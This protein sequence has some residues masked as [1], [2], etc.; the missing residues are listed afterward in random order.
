MHDALKHYAR[1][2]VT[3]ED[4]R[5]RPVRDLV[6][7]IPNVEVYTAIDLGCG[8]ANSTEVLVQRYPAAQVGGIDNSPDMIDAARRRLP[9]L[10]FEVASV[11]TWESPKPLDVILANA[12]LQWV[13]DHA[14]LYPRLIQQLTPGGTLAVQTPDNF[15]EPGHRLLVEIAARD[16]WRD[17]FGDYERNP[18]ESADWYYGMLRP[19]CSRVDVWRTTYYHAL[20]GGINGIVE[21]FKGSALRPYLERLNS[22]EQAAFL[23]EYTAEMAKAYTVYDDGVAL[24]PFPRLFVMATR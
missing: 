16:A 12:S 19:H 17:R 4:E 9:N 13:P 1:Q 7:A 23:E 24:L 3:F 10:A 20:K 18:R 22:K 2:Y 8:P 6:A 14:T 15:N 5:T 21:W 11:E